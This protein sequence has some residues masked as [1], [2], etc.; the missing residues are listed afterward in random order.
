MATRSRVLTALRVDAFQTL[1]QNI[2]LQGLYAAEKHRGSSQG[3]RRINHE[4]HC[5]SSLNSGYVA[6]HREGGRVGGREALHSS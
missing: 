5:C 3:G 1:L 2:S 6:K 4:S